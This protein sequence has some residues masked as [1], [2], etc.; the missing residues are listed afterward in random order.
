MSNDDP[1]Y[2]TGDLVFIVKELPHPLLTRKGNDLHVK[3]TIDLAEALT[4][5]TR[6][7]RH[8]DNHTVEIKEEGITQPGASKKIPFEGMPVHEAGSQS[9]DLYAD[10]RVKLPQKISTQ[11]KD[12][13]S[14]SF[15]C[16]N[17]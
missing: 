7:I 16:F 5:F 2:T 13:N 3:L 10:I 4:G 1:S 9:G 6:E 8:L 12:S 11:Q 17:K 14:R 15:Y